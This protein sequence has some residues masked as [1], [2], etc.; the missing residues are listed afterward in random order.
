MA[1]PLYRNG[2]KHYF[3]SNVATGYPEPI[4]FSFWTA[5]TPLTYLATG[6]LIMFAAFVFEALRAVREAAD[7]GKGLPS[8]AFAAFIHMMTMWVAYCLML[9]VMTFDVV[10]A[11]F[12]MA[13]LGLGH[14]VWHTGKAK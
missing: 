12:I 13:G 10:F 9:V 6:L 1:P 8:R 7:D 5:E 4:L 3:H 2:M 14:L 11:G